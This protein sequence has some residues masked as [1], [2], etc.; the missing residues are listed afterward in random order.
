MFILKIRIRENKGKN[1]G[2]IVHT[3]LAGLSILETADF[4]T[5]AEHFKHNICCSLMEKNPEKI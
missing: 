3:I 4:M 2:M 1:C 5:S